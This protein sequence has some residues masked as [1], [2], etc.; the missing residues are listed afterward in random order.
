[1]NGIKKFGLGVTC[2]VIA[3]LGGVAQAQQIGTAQAI[4]GDDMGRI[5]AA[6]KTFGVIATAVIVADSDNDPE[7]D[8]EIAQT[9]LSELLENVAFPDPYFNRSSISQSVLDMTIA[10]LLADP[11]I[12]SLV[13]SV[14]AREQ[15]GL[16][17]DTIVNFPGQ[18]AADLLATA[19]MPAGT[20]S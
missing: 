1:M 8:P 19:Q 20:G 11:E 6:A 4:G 5:S 18:M 3:G 14:I 9:T 7:L 13:E 15:I 12:M 10:E 16:L 17:V 2:V